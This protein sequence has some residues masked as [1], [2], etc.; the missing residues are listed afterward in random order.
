MSGSIDIDHVLA[1]VQLPDLIGKDVKLIKDGDSWKGL[2]PF[3][4]EKTPSF[5]I[6]LGKDGRERYHCFGCRARGDALD[7]LMKTRGVSLPQA[8]EII[9]GEANDQGPRHK[10]KN[11]PPAHDPYAGV[12]PLPMPPM[13]PMPVLGEMIKVWN[14]KRERYSTY[15]PASVYRYPCGVVLRIEFDDGGKITPQIMWCK[16]DGKTEWSHYA[17]PRPRP[18]YGIERLK[19]GKQVMI[20]EGE[21][22][23]DAAYELMNMPVVTWAG[24]TNAVEHSDWSVLAGYSVIIVPDADKRGREAADKIAAILYRLGER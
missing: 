8:A 23:A 13:V 3:H 18:L 7:Y 5:N 10:R 6:F 15:T 22:T 21:K 2:C 20:V 11:P 9:T 4:K 1:M 24:G 14:P 19:P 12:N 17:F 16:H